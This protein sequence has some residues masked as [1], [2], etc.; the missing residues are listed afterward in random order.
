MCP[1]SDSGQTGNPKTVVTEAEKTFLLSLA[2]QTLDLYLK[3]R[4]MPEVDPGRLS[5]RLTTAKGCFVTL[6]VKKTHDLRGCIGYIF[7]QGPLYKSVMENAVNAAVR[8]PRFPKVTPGEL[9]ELELEISVLTIPEDLGFS[10]P[11][12]LLEKLEPL[13][14]GVVLKTRY[15]SSTF[16]PQVWEDLPDKQEFLSRLCMKHGAP[17]DEWKKGKVQVQT[18][19]VVVFKE[20]GGSGK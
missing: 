19:Q 10:G 9:P 8:D 4:R 13:R 18:Y 5:E 11:E 16:L 7:P 6:H 20:K 15:G 17:A 14:D 3:D 1:A 12:D 2:R